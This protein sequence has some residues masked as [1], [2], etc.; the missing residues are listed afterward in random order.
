MTNA[1]ITGPGTYTVG[2]EFA[3]EAQG[4][5]FA[6]VGV[7]NGEKT[8]NGYFI[9]VTE[10]KVNGE[11]IALGKGY[12]TSDDGVTT[13]ENLYNEWVGEI[14]AEARRADGDLEGVSAIIVDKEAFAAV[15]TVEVTFNYI[16]G[17]PIV[18][19]ESAPLTE[20]EI[21]ALKS[22]SYNA[23]IGIQT[24]KYTFRN[25]WNEAN[26]GRDS[27]DNPGFFNR[28]TGWDADNNAV[29]YGGVFEDAVI[30][31]NGEYTV[32]LTTGDMGFAEDDTKI[33][34]LFVSTEIPARAIADEVITISDVKVKFGSGATQDYTNVY[35]DGT[36]A[37]I[38]LLDEYN[39][40]DEP[41]AYTMPIGPN[42]P[43]VI[44]F[45]VS[46]MAE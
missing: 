17:K 40:S 6:A 22:G 11:A 23:Y 33:R 12:T 13:R 35:T 29:D 9:D 45:T 27:Q 32:S 5:A 20:D 38:T 21:N 24:E 19:D 8:F 7:V 37:R 25:E 4:L 18:K 34:L 30:N 36:Y 39:L 31:K 28:L 43:I 46:G 1:E 10:V 3:D 14:P 41:V 15:K 42:T 44:T 26:Y 16:Y 2:L